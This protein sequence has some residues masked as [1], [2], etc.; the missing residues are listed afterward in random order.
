MDSL[1]RDLSLTD[2]TPVHKPIDFLHP[3]I[4]ICVIASDIYLS[5]E[6]RDRIAQNLYK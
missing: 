6:L 5:D 2:T 3:G 4:E 1:L